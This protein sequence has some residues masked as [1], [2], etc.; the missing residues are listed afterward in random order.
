MD[1]QKVIELIVLWL[2]DQLKKSKQKSFIIGVSGGIDS[3]LVST[4]CAMTGEPTYCFHLGINSKNKRSQEHMTWL[5]EKWPNVKG[6]NIDL[7]DSCFYMEDAISSSIEKPSED[8]FLLMLANIR[9]R[10]RMVALYAFA[11]VHNGLVVGTGN[12]IEDFAL[13]FFSK[14]GDGG[15]DISPIGDLLKSEVRELAVYLG[16]NADIVYA[17]P[18]DGLWDD[19]R[20]DEDQIGASYNE[21]E[22]AM[23]RFPELEYTDYDDSVPI[24][25]LI[26]YFTKDI[27]ENYLMG[28]RVELTE[29]EKEVNR[30]FLTRHFKNRHKMKMPPICKFIKRVEGVCDVR[31]N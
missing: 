9:S 7:A 1:H 21:L 16:I 22:A 11:N 26:E 5:T 3:A 8:T 19:D 20:S 28:V 12:K 6:S 24:E 30:I 31:C 25:E 4:L 15:I 27:E 17:V 10:L 2:K 18:T 23:K 13:G 14:Y 29:R